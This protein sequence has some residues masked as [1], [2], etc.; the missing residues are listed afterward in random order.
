MFGEIYYK[1]RFFV[2]PV[3]VAFVMMGG[4]LFYEKAEACINLS[5]SPSSVSRAGGSI[6]FLGSFDNG[7]TIGPCTISGDVPP[8]TKIASVNATQLLLQIS[9]NSPVGTYRVGFHDAQDSNTSASFTFEV[10]AASANISGAGVAVRPI[11]GSL[12]PARV[13]AGSR[14]FELDV[15]GYNFLP[16]A[17]AFLD[18]IAKVTKFISQN[19][20]KVDIAASDIVNPGTRKVSVKNSP[21]TIGESI[22]EF[23]GTLH[24]DDLTLEERG[25]KVSLFGDGGSVAVNVERRAGLRE[26][27]FIASGELPK[28]ILRLSLN[29]LD[30]AFAAKSAGVLKIFKEGILEQEKDVV[31][32]I[33]AI[34]LPV[35]ETESFVRNF[36][37]INSSGEDVFDVNVVYN[38]GKL[39]KFLSNKFTLSSKDIDGLTAGEGVFTIKATGL[40]GKFTNTS[41]DVVVQ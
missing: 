29:S 18:G 38:N 35:S 37:F 16:D 3:M 13:K 31:P 24:I 19:L 14:G 23:F 36:K 10:V 22:S 25:L 28:E 2:L 12:I 32:G 21:G 27:S 41:A 26:V 20:L 39:V 7:S 34:S 30:L 9:P 6:T 4:F 11:I 1:M 33:F 15:E 8:G 40:D 17:K 5:R